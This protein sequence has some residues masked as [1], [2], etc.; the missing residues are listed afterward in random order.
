MVQSDYVGTKIK[1]LA[2]VWLSNRNEDELQDYLEYNDVEPS[3]IYQE[4]I[5]FDY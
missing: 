1:F 5:C 4:S 2:E 3:S